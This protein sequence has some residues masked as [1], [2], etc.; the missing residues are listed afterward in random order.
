MYSEVGTHEVKVFRDLLMLQSYW[1]ESDRSNVTGLIHVGFVRPRLDDAK[2]F[3]RFF[4]KVLVTAAARWALPSNYP[5]SIAAVA[6]LSFADQTLPCY[7]V[8]D[9]FGYEAAEGT[10]NEQY[11]YSITTSGPLNTLTMAEAAQQVLNEEKMPLTIETIYAYIMERGLYQ[12]SA[13]KPLSAFTAELNKHIYDDTDSNYATA[14]L[15]GKTRDGLLYSLDV[16]SGEPVG[17]VS[18][19]A[20]RNSDI[21][22]ELSPRGIFCEED[23][24]KQTS[25]LPLSFRDKVD[26]LRFSY[27]K[28]ETDIQ[29]IK[30]LLDILPHGVLNEKID[31]LGL[32]VR[33]KNVLKNQGISCI[34]ELDSYGLSTIRGWPNIGKK[35]LE[36]LC[37]SLVRRS[38]SLLEKPGQFHV[39]DENMSNSGLEVNEP[40]KHNEYQLE[41]IS[42]IPLREH[43]LKN[44]LALND[45]DQEIIRSRTG[46]YGSVQTLEEIGLRLDVTRERIR[47]IQKK[48]I[49][50]II[51]SE[52]WD[53]VIA[54]KIGQ[55]LVDRKTPLYLEMLEMEDSWF[56]GFMDN[57]AHLAGIIEIFSENQ[58]R[59]VK[60]NGANIVTRIRIDDWQNIV[61]ELRHT[62]KAKANEGGWSRQDVNTLFESR[63]MASGA[64]ELQALLWDEFSGSMHFDGEEDSSKLLSF[65]RTAESAVEAVLYQA[66][67]PLHY[68]EIAKR[69]TELFGKTVDERRAQ[70]ALQG[71]GAR[72]Y[73]RGIYGLEKFNPISPRMCNNICLVVNRLIKTGPL[74]KQWHSDEI[75]VQLKKQFPALP[76]ELDNYLL[77]IILSRSNELVYLNRM[78]WARADSGQGVADRIDMA[79][80]FT[81]ILEE[82]GGPLKGSELKQK[83]SEIRGVVSSMQLQPTDRMILIG[84]DYWGLIDRDIG[85]TAEENRKRLDALFQHLQESQK[86]IH[87]REVEACLVKYGFTTDNAPTSYALLNLAQRDKRFYLGRSMFLGLSDW[88]EDTK[89]VNITQ[90]VRKVVGEMTQPMNIGEINARVEDLTGL[91]VEATV[92]GLLVKA[93]AIYDSALKAWK[94]SDLSS[95]V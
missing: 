70:N 76:E 67:K 51:D 53:D 8:L 90:A 66:E 4:G 2:G 27:L 94:K 15:F 28:K 40:D 73:G 13:N 23:Y 21:F 31:N 86:G 85:G 58:I 87:V 12:F 56:A 39:G 41:V 72:L 52:F 38:E 14:F 62:L 54:I 59:V 92:V 42:Q 91:E 36:D 69:A 89:R 17:W 78:V 19:V 25:S 95:I 44:L 65:G 74:M 64:V 3:N 1:T 83:L 7:L 93:G 22:L 5:C 18:E 37:S 26:F 48:Y 11:I 55:L 24:Q 20:K 6:E 30:E 9:R 81:K 33:V 45:R 79:D 16:M 32:P 46:Y 71:Q 61:S 29:N 35:S 10:T 80:A 75:L 63:L 47:Q 50:K 82:H 49:S 84:P 43:F 77:N 88:G 60:I 34:R 57:Y 68:S